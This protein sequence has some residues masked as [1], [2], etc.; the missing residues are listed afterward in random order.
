MVEEDVGVV[1]V[2]VE[3]PAA[4]HADLAVAAQRVGVAKRHSAARH[5]LQV[6]AALHF[7]KGLR[8]T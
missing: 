8:V 5:Q 6:T 1:G 4:A 7:W 2:L 3:G